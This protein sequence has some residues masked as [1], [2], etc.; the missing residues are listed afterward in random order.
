[1]QIKDKVVIVTGAASG[2]GRALAERFRAE[3]AV[4]V[5]VC[6]IDA[7]RIRSVAGAIGCEAAVCDVT[8]FDAVK[9]VVDDTEKRFGRI[10][11]YCANAGVLLKGGLETPDET[12][13]QVMDIN[14]MAH[15]HAA[16]ACLPGMIARGGGAFLNTVSAAGLLS[17]IGAVTYTVTKHAALGFAEWLAITHG[18]QGIQ[19][20]VLCPQAVQTPMI[21]HVPDGG[22]AGMDGVVTPEHVADCAVEALAANRFMALPHPEVKKYF[23]RKAADHDNWI[24]AMQRLRQKFPEG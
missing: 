15:V 14:L 9:Q 22:V 16:R 6:D 12:W 20:T 19:V 3:G 4:A 11:L 5:V 17:Q 2:I 21:D 1:M 23:Q 7:D 24:S 8:D 10:D 13:R 18:H